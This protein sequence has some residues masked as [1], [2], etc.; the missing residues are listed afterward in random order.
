LVT[1][2]EFVVIVEGMF[3]AI[4]LPHKN[5]GQRGLFVFQD[6]LT[7]FCVIG[8]MV[9]QKKGKEICQ[10]TTPSDRCIPSTGP[11]LS[12]CLGALPLLGLPLGGI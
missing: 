9:A 7:L 1:W 2:Q 10:V 6:A 3:F 8:N 11:P 12:S 4:I 5:T